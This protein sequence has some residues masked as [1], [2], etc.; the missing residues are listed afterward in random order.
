M[1]PQ[2]TSI[3]VDV[4]GIRVA[5]MKLHSDTEHAADVLRSDLN[6]TAV[7]A[8]GFGD[9]GLTETYAEVSKAARDVI[10]RVLRVVADHADIMDKTADEWDARETQTAKDVSGI[11]LPG[12]VIMP[13]SWQA[14]M[15]APDGGS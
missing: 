6:G 9:S 3:V 14:P 13:S 15:V 12:D 10:A 7:I 11:C 2:Q 4:D 8:P 1:G 5:A